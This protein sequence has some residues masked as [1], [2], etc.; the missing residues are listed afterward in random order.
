M[1]MA[2]V[3]GATLVLAGTAQAAEVTPRGGRVGDE[4]AFTDAGNVTRIDWGDGS[5]TPPDA[6]HRYAA[7]GLYRVTVHYADNGSSE[8][9]LAVSAS[10]DLIIGVTTSG[11]GLAGHVFTKEGHPA[12]GAI[13]TSEPGGGTGV[14]DADGAYVIEDFPHSLY[15]ATMTAELGSLSGSFTPVRPPFDPMVFFGVSLATGIG[16]TLWMLWPL[17]RTA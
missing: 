4:F 11:A 14:A 12:A 16:I 8:I 13:V 2:L 3:L 5:G 1:I 6:T 9:P 7:A 10:P 15:D 17:R